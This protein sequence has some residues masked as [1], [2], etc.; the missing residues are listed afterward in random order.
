MS[1]HAKSVGSWE[2]TNESD[3]Y[4]YM[5]TKR[6]N[7]VDYVVNS[8]LGWINPKSKGV[9]KSDDVWF[10]HQGLSDNDKVSIGFMDGNNRVIECANDI[11][12]KN[13][14]SIKLNSNMDCAF[15]Y[16]SKYT[17]RISAYNLIPDYTDNY[18][19]GFKLPTP[20]MKF[21]DLTTSLYFGDVIKDEVFDYSHHGFSSVEPDTLVQYAIKSSNK[22]NEINCGNPVPA[23]GTY[24]IMMSEGGC[25][26]ID[27]D[28]LVK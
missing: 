11:Q 23:H 28:A 21:M 6:H 26:L 4:V 12:L 20:T 18:K 3:Q 1:V 10:Q 27:Y 17:T 16:D 7:D 13:N 5:V 25:D 2:Y 15:K 14:I 22:K 19:V 24:Y 8:I 9:I